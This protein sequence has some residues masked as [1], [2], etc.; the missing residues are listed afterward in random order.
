M[1]KFALILLSLTLF[2]GQTGAQRQGGS[3]KDKVQQQKKKGIDYDTF[4]KDV[5]VRYQA[6]RDSVNSRYAA[7]MERVWKG[8]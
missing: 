1:K 5:N 8:L 6:F 3:L 2:V 7:M 4:V